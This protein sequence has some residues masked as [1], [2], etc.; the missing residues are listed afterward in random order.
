MNDDHAYSVSEAIS[1][2][3]KIQDIIKLECEIEELK[4]Q[5]RDLTQALDDVKN[6][7]DQN[8]RFNIYHHEF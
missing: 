4:K 6:Y 2:A 5:I 1:S 3:K 7:H 8:E